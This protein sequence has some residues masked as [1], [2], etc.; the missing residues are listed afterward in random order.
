[1]KLGRLNSA[2]LCLNSVDVVRFGR[3]LFSQ[4]SSVCFSVDE[5]LSFSHAVR[6]AMAGCSSL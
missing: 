3:T 1:M 4:F 5:F 6:N 2:L